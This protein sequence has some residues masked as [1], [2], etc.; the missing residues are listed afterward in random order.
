MPAVEYD[1]ILFN[2][3]FPDSDWYLPAKL[4]DEQ[5]AYI[6]Q[7]LKRLDMHCTIHGCGCA[8]WNREMLSYPDVSDY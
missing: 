1:Y 3:Y 6:E 8:P 4:S 5:N 7:T 2:I